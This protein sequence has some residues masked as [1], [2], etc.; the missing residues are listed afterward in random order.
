MLKG[1]DGGK[2][3][4][5][6]AEIISAQ[7]V[8][9]ASLL[10]IGD[11]RFSQA[12]A[13]MAWQAGE[14]AQI[15]KVFGI[16]LAKLTALTVGESLEINQLNPTIEVGGTKYAFRVHIKES[17]QPTE[18]EANPANGGVEKFAKIN[19]TTQKQ[20]THNGNLIFSH[21]EVAL[22]PVGENPE[23]IMLKGDSVESTVTTMAA[24]AGIEL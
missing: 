4:I 19:P 21:T 11:A 17:V 8:N 2:I 10:N 14:P 15:A 9:S 7:A 20:I 18:Y 6:I 1:L 16:E 22:L 5:E 24:S 13:R 3:Q 23:H 12:K